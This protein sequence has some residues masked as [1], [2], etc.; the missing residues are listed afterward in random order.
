MK[1][2]LYF[3]ATYSTHHI[4]LEPL[5][6]L[7]EAWCCG[8]CSS[9]LTS[10][11]RSF[12]Y[13]HPVSSWF[14]SV[15]KCLFSLKSLHVL[16]RVFKQRVTGSTERL[17][18]I[19][20]FVPFKKFIIVTSVSPFKFVSGSPL[21]HPL[22]WFC[23]SEAKMGCTL[24]VTRHW[25]GVGKAP[26]TE[27]RSTDS[28]WVCATGPDISNLWIGVDDSDSGVWGSSK[29]H[30]TLF[31][32]KKFYCFT[33]TKWRQGP[34]QQPSPSW[35]CGVYKPR[36]R[37]SH[38][39]PRRASRAYAVLHWQP[40]SLGSAAKGQR[41]MYILPPH[42]PTWVDVDALSAIFV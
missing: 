24:A 16:N 20:P 13:L 37:L 9:M 28:L 29:V 27:T 36:L 31:L 2:C 1:R 11:L 34:H 7:K 19:A 32:F 3:N 6:T 21:N 42:H 15:H 38:R 23:K 41:W 25:T 12:L 26:N 10:N 35:R 17:K 14:T 33:S 5:Y 40:G 22:I 8:D 4:R 30:L 39:E 18:P